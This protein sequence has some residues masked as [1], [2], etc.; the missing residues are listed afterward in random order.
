MLGRGMSALS[1]HISLASCRKALS[2]LL[3]KRYQADIDTVSVDL[4]PVSTWIIR[5]TSTP[6]INALLL[7]GCSQVTEYFYSKDT[8]S[9]PGSATKLMPRSTGDNEWGFHSF[10]RSG[11]SRFYLKWYEDFLPSARDLCPKTVTLLDS[12]PSVHGAMFTMLARSRCWLATVPLGPRDTEFR[13]ML[14]LC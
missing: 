9:L 7:T 1:R 2:F 14:Y 3:P 5:A 10:F 12:I 8:V 13:S 4:A 6:V 11:W